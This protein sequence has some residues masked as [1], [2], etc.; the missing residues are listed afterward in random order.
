MEKALISERFYIIP[1]CFLHDQ[2]NFRIFQI[3]FFPLPVRDGMTHGIT[4]LFQ[5]EDRFT[6]YGFG[7]ETSSLMEDDQRRFVHYSS[8]SY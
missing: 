7:N 3:V 6:D 4:I 1:V 8:A 5:R 2:R